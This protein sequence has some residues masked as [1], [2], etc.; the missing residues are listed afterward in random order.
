MLVTV[1][2]K[3]P[4]DA[5]AGGDLAGWVI[6]PATGEE[7]SIDDAAELVRFLTEQGRTCTN[8]ARP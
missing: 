4:L 3:V 7:A 8:G 2:L 5:L 6:C 1:L